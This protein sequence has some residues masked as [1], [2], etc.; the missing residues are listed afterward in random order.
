MTKSELIDRLNAIPGDPEICILD[1]FNG[2][3]APRTINFGPLLFNGM[4]EFAGDERADYSDICS[5]AETPIIVIG[6]GCY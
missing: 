4:A 6:Y 2:G 5:A 1:G 3:G